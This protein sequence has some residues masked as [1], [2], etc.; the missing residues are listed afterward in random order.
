MNSERIEELQSGLQIITDFLYQEDLGAAYSALAAWLPELE[1]VLSSID[2][3][4]VREELRDQLMQALDAME[5]GDHILLADLLQYEIN[6]RLTE[7][8]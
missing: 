7:L 5:E 2:K 6:D 3:E 8:K 1:N 4:D